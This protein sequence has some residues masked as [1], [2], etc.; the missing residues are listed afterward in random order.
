M[1]RKYNISEYGIVSSF[2]YSHHQATGWKFSVLVYDAWKF[3]HTL[4]LVGICL[5]GSLDDY[6]IVECPT[7]QEAERFCDILPLNYP[8]LSIWEN[9]KLIYDSIKKKIGNERE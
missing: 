5:N 9:G 2:M 1:N 8:R 3:S 4:K 7:M 6:L